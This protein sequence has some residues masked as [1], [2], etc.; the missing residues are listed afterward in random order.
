M[1]SYQH[2]FAFVHVYKMVLN[3]IRNLSFNLDLEEASKRRVT[4]MSIAGHPDIIP[5]TT[6]IPVK[7][8]E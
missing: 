4:R 3:N 6:I 2:K 8:T 5:H 1:P 7:Y